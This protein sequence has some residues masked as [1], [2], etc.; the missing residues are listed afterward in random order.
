MV[1]Q[2][3]TIALELEVPDSPDNQ[4]GCW[5]NSAL[6]PQF[7]PGARDVHVLFENVRERRRTTISH[8]SV[9][10]SPVQECIT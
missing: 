7:H 8:L 6:P 3:Y 5:F 4:V 1:G 9:Q 2:P 10:P